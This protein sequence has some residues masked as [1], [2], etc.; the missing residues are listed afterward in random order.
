MLFR[1]MMV[2]MNSRYMPW[3]RYI[4]PAD[5]YQTVRF[6]QEGAR[7]ARERQH[8]ERVEDLTRRFAD[9]DINDPVDDLTRRFA[10]LTLNDHNVM[11]VVQNLR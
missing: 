5:H 1:G 10:S 7:H 6:A 9:L 8:R 11:T 2:D 4:G 3:Q